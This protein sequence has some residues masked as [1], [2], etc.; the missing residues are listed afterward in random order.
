MKFQHDLITRFNI[1]V[2]FECPRRDGD[3]PENPSLDPEYLKARFDLFE[4]YTVP[5]VAHQTKKDFS[6]IV[7]F[8]RDTPDVFKKRIEAIKSRCENFIPLYL[9]DEQ[10]LHFVS[11]MDDFIA[12]HCWGDHVLTSRLDNDDAISTDYIEAV[13]SCVQ[14][15]GPGTY[16]ISMEYGLQYDVKMKLA[17]RYLYRANHFLS[18]LTPLSAEKKTVYSFNHAFLD[19]YDIDVQYIQGTHAYWAEIIHASNYSNDL[20]LYPWSLILN[21][22][23]RQYYDFIDWTL[24]TFITHVLR[25]ACCIGK[26]DIQKIAR[27]VK[28]VSNT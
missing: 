23:T 15:H 28:R 5:S 18:M 14:N 2:K 9:D 20:A 21:Y 4:A 22:G 25:S 27:K 17:Y 26:A 6:W 1:T 13:Q 11:V 8:H 16:I 19:T 24:G 12:Q 3:K 10:S 7:L